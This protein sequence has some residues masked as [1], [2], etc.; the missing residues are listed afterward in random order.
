MSNKEWRKEAENSLEKTRIEME[1]YEK[2][3]RNSGNIKNYIDDEGFRVREIISEDG[4]LKT[5]IKKRESNGKLESRF[6]IWKDGE[7]IKDDIREYP[8]TPVTK[9]SGNGCLVIA[10]VT[11]LAIAIVIGAIIIL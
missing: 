7:K 9:S 10:L 8:I 3:L 4:K 1:N 5:I 11:L 2:K 6:T